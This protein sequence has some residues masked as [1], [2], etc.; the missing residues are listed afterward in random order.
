MLFLCVSLN[1]N[2]LLLPVLSNYS[3]VCGAFTAHV[4]NTVCFWLST[5]PHFFI[6]FGQELNKHGLLSCI[7]PNKK[8]NLDSK[9]GVLWSSEMFFTEELE[10]YSFRVDCVFCKMDLV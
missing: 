3:E 8:Y 5:V 2:E 9:F 7:F 4:L 1:V 6:G 10:N